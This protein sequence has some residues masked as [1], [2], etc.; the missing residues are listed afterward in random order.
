MTRTSPRPTRDEC[1]QSPGRT[2]QSAAMKAY[3]AKNEGD[4]KKATV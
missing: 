1:A 4:T 3:C 2:R